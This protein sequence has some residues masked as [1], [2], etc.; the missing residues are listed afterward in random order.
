MK[1]NPRDRVQV[2]IFA[3]EAGVNPP[4][5]ALG[6]VAVGGVMSSNAQTLGIAMD[7]MGMSMNMTRLS[8][9]KPFDREF[10]DMMTPHHQGA[11]TMARAELAKG[12]DPQLRTLA[13]S[14]ISDQTREIGEMSAWRIKWY[15]GA[16][17]PGAAVAAGG[18]QGM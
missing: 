16:V 12:V 13:Q 3:Y 15:G 7:K 1:L 6:R 17:P 10:I 18:T 11:I 4:R 2:V 8:A 5:G 14:I 9:A